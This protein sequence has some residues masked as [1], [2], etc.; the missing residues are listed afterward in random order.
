VPVR[1]GRAGEEHVE[2][3]LHEVEVLGRT[4]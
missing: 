2:I 4:C 1:D 3:L